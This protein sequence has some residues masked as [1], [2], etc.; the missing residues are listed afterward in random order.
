VEFLI[1]E[2]ERHPNEITILAIGPLTN[3]ALALRMKPAIETQIKQ[4]VLMGGNVHVAG[5]ASQAAEFNFWFDPEAAA[6]VLRSRIP[7]KV[8]FALDICNRAPI[9]KAEFDQIVAAH[10]PVT[11]LFA[12]DLGNRYPAFNRNP[13]RTTYLW[14]SHPAAW[15]HDPGIDTKS[16]SRRLY[17]VSTWGKFYG[18]TKPLDAR[19][20][21]D[22]SPVTLM[23]ELNFARVFELFKQR[24]TRKD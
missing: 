13:K 12:D 18:S 14:D 11:D 9:R 4:I 19:V 22:A 10:T 20:A 3:I 23:L 8:M 6:I 17:V 21:P 7:R 16:E 2:I 15:L 1:S 5:N 24:L